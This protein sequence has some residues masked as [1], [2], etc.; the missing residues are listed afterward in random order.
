VVQREILA[1]DEVVA[2]SHDSVPLAVLGADFDVRSVDGSLFVLLERHGVQ[3]R[4]SLTNI[5]ASHGEDVGWGDHEDTTLFL[6]LEQAHFD[7]G[8]RGVAF[9]RTWF[10]EGRFQFSIVRVR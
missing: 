5:H 6:L 9:A 2:Y 7:E 1:D 10:I 3:V 4:S 8:N